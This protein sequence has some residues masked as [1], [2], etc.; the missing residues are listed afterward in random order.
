MTYKLFDYVDEHGRN[1]IK[2]WSESLEKTQRARLNEMLDKLAMHGDTLHPKMM[3]GSG[4]AG[5]SKLRVKGPVQ[6]R[7]LLCRGPVDV[8][9]EYTLLKGAK[10]VGDKWKPENAREI[11]K[12]H[13]EKVKKNAVE[14]RKVHEQVS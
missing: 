3:A 7:P 11:A 4:V 1:V 12:E 2:E 5:I 8:A 10:E 13:K 9:G 14:R 6:L